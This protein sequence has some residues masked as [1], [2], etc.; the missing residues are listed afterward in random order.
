[1]ERVGSGDPLR[2]R[3][4]TLALGDVTPRNAM[5][6]AGSFCQKYWSPSDPAIVMPIVLDW[7]W[8][9]ATKRPESVGNFGPTPGSFG[10]EI[11]D[12][13]ASGVPGSQMC[14]RDALYRRIPLSVDLVIRRGSFCTVHWVCETLRQFPS[15]GALEFGGQ[16]RTKVTSEAVSRR[17]S[18][19]AIAWL[20]APLFIDDPR[21]SRF[22]D[23][24]SFSNR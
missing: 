22:R 23:F 1:M 5:N 12:P 24:V 17:S 2:S 8:M 4:N 9:V 14:S 7:S 21:F 11:V 15:V 20:S 13:K 16:A 3:E 18:T 10:P 19:H 6:E